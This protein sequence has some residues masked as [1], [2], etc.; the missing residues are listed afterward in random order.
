[1]VFIRRLLAIVTFHIVFLAAGAAHAALI[2]SWQFDQPYITAQPSDRIPITA[3]ITN[4]AASDQTF[5]PFELSSWGYTYSTESSNRAHEYYFLRDPRFEYPGPRQT[6][7]TELGGLVLTP[8]E[9][10]QFLFFV[11]VPS[12]GITGGGSVPYGSYDFGQFNLYFDSNNGANLDH[13]YVAQNELTVNVVPVPAA[14]WLLVSGVAG[15]AGV[16]VRSRKRR[17]P[18]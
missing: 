16:G 1:M 15:L 18:H 3:T 8:G 13:Y 5:D 14:V 6:L 17:S 7:W 10:H 9:S 2:V 11:L 4:S 12:N